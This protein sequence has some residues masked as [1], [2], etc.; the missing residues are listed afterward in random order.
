M[1]RKVDRLSIRRTAYRSD[2][3]HLDK[4]QSADVLR[5]VLEPRLRWSEH[6]AWPR[7]AAAMVDDEL[8]LGI[9]RAGE[10]EVNDI[11]HVRAN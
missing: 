8:R 5:P 2:I 7:I 4:P 11:G 6:E 1:C 9:I 10:V 3:Q